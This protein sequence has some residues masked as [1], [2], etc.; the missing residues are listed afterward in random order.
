MQ[1]EAQWVVGFTDGEGRF[2]V[3]IARHPQMSAGV[4][5]R[6]EFAIVQHKRDVKVLHALKRFFG[7][8]VVRS[9]HGD[10]LCWR[11]RKLEHLRDRII[12]FFDRHPLKTLKRQDYL[13]FRRV[14]MLMST[15]E[16]LGPEGLKRVRQVAARMRRQ[17]GA[18]DSGKVKS[19]SPRKR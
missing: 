3:G 18:G 16:H 11:V 1:L 5:V 15:G 12:P 17:R 7:C 8:G 6:P 13:A 2:H 19:S 10:R 4:Q 14:V 9:N